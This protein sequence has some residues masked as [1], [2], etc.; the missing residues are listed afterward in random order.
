MK[1]AMMIEMAS[2]WTV[3]GVLD[4][5]ARTNDLPAKS[6]SRIKNRLASMPMCEYNL[7]AGL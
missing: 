5:M 4:L 6:S 2:N 3:R 1:L 7:E